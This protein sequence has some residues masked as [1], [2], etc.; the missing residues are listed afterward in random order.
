M[1]QFRIGVGDPGQ[2]R[3]IDLG[4]QAEQDVADHDA[5]MIA[6]DVGEL[7]PAGG[8]ADREDAAVGGAQA[9]IDL[10]PLGENSMPAASRP[11]PATLARR[12]AATSRSDAF[13]P[14][15][16]R[17][18]GGDAVAVALDAGDLDAFAEIDAFGCQAVADD[19]D[20]VGIVLRQ[21][22]AFSRTVTSA[23]SRR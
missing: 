8:V 6:G 5:G 15:A 22:R 10:M 1:G 18:H 3:V 2:R 19:G 13:D 9:G 14:G 4:R 17:E 23:P 7:R 20:Q 16:V 11:R 12:P 21:Q